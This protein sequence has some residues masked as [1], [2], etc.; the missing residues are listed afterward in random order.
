MKFSSQDW[1][2][3]LLDSGSSP[4]KGVVLITRIIMK[5]TTIINT[6]AKMIPD[7]PAISIVVLARAVPTV[8]P[9]MQMITILVYIALL[10]ACIL[11]FFNF[12]FILFS[13]FTGR[14]ICIQVQMSILYDYGVG[15]IFYEVNNAKRYFYEVNNAKRY[16]LCKIC[17]FLQKWYTYKWFI[18][19]NFFDGFIKAN[20]ILEE[21]LLFVAYPISFGDL[22]YGSIIRI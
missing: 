22:S 14:I 12:L 20:T 3:R 18:L 13:F 2:F 17:I 9:N 16:F 10:R 4:S 6:I 7:S 8:M 11:L 21:T 19:L 15:G 1:F 5:N